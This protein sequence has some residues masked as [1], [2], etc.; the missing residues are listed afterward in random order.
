M[1][2]GSYDESEQRE[3]EYGEEEDDEGGNVDLHQSDHQGSVSFESG[4]STDD[5]LERLEDYKDDPDEG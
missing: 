1:G 5:L 2:F 4:A 3:P